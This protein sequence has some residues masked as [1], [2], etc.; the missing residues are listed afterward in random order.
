MIIVYILFLSILMRVL[1]QNIQNYFLRFIPSFIPE[2]L[3]L[4]LSV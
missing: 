3:S 2:P 1:Y 4:S